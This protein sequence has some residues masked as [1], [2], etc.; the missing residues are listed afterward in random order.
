MVSPITMTNEQFQELLQN[1][2]LPTADN[3]AVVLSTRS[4]NFAKCLSRFDGSKYSDVKAFIDAIEIYKDCSDVSDANALKGLPMLLDGFAA[5]WQGVKTTIDTWEA[6]IMLLIHTYGPTKPPHKVYRELFKSEQDA[7]TPTD[8]F[9]CNSRSILAQLLA[10]MLTEQIQLDMVYGLLHTRIREKVPRNKIVNF[11]ELLEQARIV[12]DN[13]EDLVKVSRITKIEEQ[14][15]EPNKPR[16]GFCKNIDHIKEDCRKF[17]TKQNRINESV[18]KHSGSTSASSSAVTT[19]SG[20]PLT[21]YGCGNPGYIRSNFP[22]CKS[23]VVNSSLDFCE[24][25]AS[26]HF[27]VTPRSRPIMYVR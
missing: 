16:C 10:N 2:R 15:K 23:A 9:I 26:N 5:T 25:S 6:A 4:G 7:R 11:S 12:E 3:N 21:C 19:Q 22:T 27:R 13:F 1:I 18:D 24:V 17:A 14:P 8:V 20:K